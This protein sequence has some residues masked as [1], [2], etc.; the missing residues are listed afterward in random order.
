MASLVEDEAR[1]LTDCLEELLVLE[2]GRESA[3][4]CRLPPGTI[5]RERLR[6][7]PGVLRLVARRWSGGPAPV[8]ADAGRGAGFEPETS[9]L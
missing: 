1:C 6:A 5:R 8:R 9:C 3:I 2:P 4:R 7:K